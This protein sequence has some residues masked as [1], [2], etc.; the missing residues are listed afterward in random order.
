M[1][2]TRAGMAILK[3]YIKRAEKLVPVLRHLGHDSG[4]AHRMNG[5][6]KEAIA[7]QSRFRD[8]RNEDI[9]WLAVK[10]MKIQD[11]A[12]TAKEKEFQGNL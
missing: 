2:L 11:D 7:R 6:A 3:S 8:F 9:F 1:P 10:I 12:A 4:A 5:Y